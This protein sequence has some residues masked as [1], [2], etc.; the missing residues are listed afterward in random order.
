M[1]KW[2][3]VLVVFTGLI[4]LGGFGRN[5]AST[6]EPTDEQNMECFL[7]ELARL[8]FYLAAGYPLALVLVCLF[9]PPATC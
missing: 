8:F 2:I 7:L 6:Y 4:M 1:K 5:R 9:I 3:L